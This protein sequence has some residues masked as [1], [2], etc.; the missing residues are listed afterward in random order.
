MCKRMLVAISV[1]SALLS[2][3]CN[4]KLDTIEFVSAKGDIPTVIKK[5]DDGNLHVTMNQMELGVVALKQEK[6]EYQL[7]FVTSN[8]PH[9]TKGR[10]FTLEPGASVGP[11]IYTCTDCVSLN[12]SDLALPVVWI[13]I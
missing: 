6:R 1:T 4:S 2:L 11:S 5:H 8:H 3:G 13:R 9:I 12:P 7:E 10:R